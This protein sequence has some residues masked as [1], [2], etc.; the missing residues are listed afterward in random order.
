MTTKLNTDWTK[1]IF[2]TLVKSQ[3]IIYS[4]IYDENMVEV[5][6]PNHMWYFYINNYLES[7]S[8]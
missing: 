7:K 8:S 5:S 4:K 1:T 6:I 3:V 2:K